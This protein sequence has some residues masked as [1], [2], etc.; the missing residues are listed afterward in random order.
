MML[1]LPGMFGMSGIKFIFEFLLLFLLLQLVYNLSKG[2]SELDALVPWLLNIQARAPGSPVVVV[3]THR[4]IISEGNKEVVLYFLIKSLELFS[5]VKKNMRQHI[6]EIITKPGTV[7][8]NTTLH[9]QW[10]DRFS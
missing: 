10:F 5:S 3:G 7:I 9:C 8:L 1:G 6:S 2:E 4:D